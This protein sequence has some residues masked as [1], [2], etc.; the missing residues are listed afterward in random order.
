MDKVEKARIE[1]E[2]QRVQ[3]IIDAAEIEA[4]NKDAKEERQAVEDMENGEKL[5]RLAVNISSDSEQEGGE[6]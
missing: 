5:L 6:T 2:A 4:R 3:R 1:T